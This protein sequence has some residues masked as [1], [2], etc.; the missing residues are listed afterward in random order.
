MVIFAHCG[1]PYFAPRF[2]GAW[3]EHSDFASVRGYLERYNGT[4][5]STGRCYADVSALAT[6]TRRSYYADVAR[7]PQRS[8]LF[9]S[10]F[11]APVFRDNDA[12]SSAELRRALRG[13]LSRLI[14]PSGNPIDANYEQ[15]AAAFPGHPMFTTFARDLVR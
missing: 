2:L 5:A 11:P 1:L 14:A 15:L 8:L 6:P 9:G 7:L 4:G 13:D 3:F 12:P 10:D